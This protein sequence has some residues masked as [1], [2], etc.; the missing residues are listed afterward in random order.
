MK[1]TRTLKILWARRIEIPGPPAMQFRG[2]A[3]FTAFAAVVVGFPRF[4]V[5]GSGRADTFIASDSE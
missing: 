1:K 2:Q 5:E 4:L 3:S